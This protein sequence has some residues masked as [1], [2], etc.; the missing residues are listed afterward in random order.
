[1]EIITFAIF[2]SVPRNK[3]KKI[4]N[5]RHPRQE[6]RYRKERGKTQLFIKETQRNCTCMF[7]VYVVAG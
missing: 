4:V 3:G 5:Q 2:N 6:K 1:M 7:I